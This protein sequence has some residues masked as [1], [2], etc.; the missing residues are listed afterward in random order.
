MSRVPRKKLELL[1]KAFTEQAMS[2][3]QA[4]ETIGVTYAAANRYYEMWGKEIKESLEEQL[5]PQIQVPQS[6]SV[7]ATVSRQMIERSKPRM[8]IIPGEDEEPFRLVGLEG[9]LP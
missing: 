4:A 7:H 3:G 6:R 5:V 1:K 8:L 2:P 9:S